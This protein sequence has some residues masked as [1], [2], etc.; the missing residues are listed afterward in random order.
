MAELATI[1]RPYAEA[2]FKL[3][4]EQNALPVWGEM[5]KF[6]GAVMS[7]PA[8]QAAIDNPK[9]G[10]DQKA[11]LFLSVC[12]D[13]LNVTGR[14]FIK[15]LVE[16]HRIVVLPQIEAMFAQLKNAAEG[17]AEAQIV[18]AIALTD[19]QVSELKVVLEKRFGKKIEAFVSVDPSLIGGARI[20]VGDQVVDGSI[21]GKLQAMATQ[22]KS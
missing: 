13:K 2:V 9:L 10:A 22:L 15:V 5:L 20:V 21:A 7:D 1:A 11:A 18:S 14:N 16:A 6:A 19:A 4:T 12:G 3:A 8:M 17:V